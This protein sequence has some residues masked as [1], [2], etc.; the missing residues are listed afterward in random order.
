M[1]NEI[2]QTEKNKLYEESKNILNLCILNIF[3]FWVKLDIS[4]NSAKQQNC[5]LFYQNN[6]WNFKEKAL[7]SD[8]SNVTL[9]Y[10]TLGKLFL[11]SVFQFPLL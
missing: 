1:L 9:S 11:H 7:E 5:A 8:I 4:E 2:G 10:V 3:S 6:N